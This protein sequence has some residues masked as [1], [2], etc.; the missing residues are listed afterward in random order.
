MAAVM[1]GDPESA[2]TPVGFLQSGR[3]EIDSVGI[4]LRS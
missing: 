2:I 4:R 1:G 3:P